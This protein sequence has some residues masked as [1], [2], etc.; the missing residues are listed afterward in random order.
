MIDSWRI[1]S[2]CNFISQV[3]HQLFEQS[4]ASD[5][6]ELDT[7]YAE[8][9]S[10]LSVKNYADF[11]HALLYFEEIYM[12][13]E[14][15]AY[16]QDRAHFIRSGEYLAYKMYKNV[17]ECRPSIIIGDMIYAQSLLPSNSS[18]NES[19]QYQGF[20]HRIK[21]D[22][23]LLKFS[24]EFHSSYLGEDYKIIFKFART[25]LIKQH[26]AIERVA[27]KMKYNGFE[28]LFPTIVKSV[29]RLQLEVELKDDEMVLQ[30][31]KQSIPW[32][33]KKLNEI[34]KRAVFNVLRGEVR[35][36]P[37]I[38]FGP[39]VSIWEANSKCISKYLLFHFARIYKLQMY[40]HF[41]TG[42]RQNVI[43]DWNDF[44]IVSQRE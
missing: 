39:P 28:Y 29:K 8:L 14:F 11:F 33:N 36:C 13:H 25:K 22:Q 3:P 2:H 43:I 23:L 9:F 10:K 40:T 27:K 4:M 31:P 16:D 17:F 5:K 26:N 38:V 7:K 24:E 37:Y 12:R 41:H 30:F 1:F 15:R 42:Y 44:A 19:N 34:Q 21:K 20:I 6:F 35:M 18:Q 32:Y